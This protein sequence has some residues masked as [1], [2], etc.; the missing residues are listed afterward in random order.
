MYAWVHIRWKKELKFD[1]Y[2]SFL[3]VCLHP[4]ICN[5]YVALNEVFVT[6]GN[7][8]IDLHVRCIRG[9]A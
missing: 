4:S 8:N 1:V 6:R 9:I 2:R 3:H 5:A 7:I